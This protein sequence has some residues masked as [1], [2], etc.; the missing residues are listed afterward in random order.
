MTALNNAR[1]QIKVNYVLISGRV[2]KKYTGEVMAIQFGAPV[3]TQTQD[4]K[5][6]RNSRSG[7]TP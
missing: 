1:V 7:F 4:P 3:T 5:V 2:P 6:R